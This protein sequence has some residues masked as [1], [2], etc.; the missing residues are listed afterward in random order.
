MK[1]YCGKKKMVWYILVS[2][3]VVLL[4]VLGVQYGKRCELQESIAG[5]VLRFHVLANSDSDIDQTLKLKVRDAVG[6]QMAEM[7]SGA[8]SLEKCEQLVAANI[9]EIER[10]AE[11][12]IAGEGHTYTVD[13]FLQEVSFPVKVYGDYAFPAGEYEALEV[14]IGAG[15]GHNWWCVMYPNMCFSGSVYEVVDE[16]AK[17][18]L[19]EVLSEDEYEAVLSSGDYEVQFKYLTFLNELME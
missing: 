2:V 4:V 5:K 1:E 17:T 7:L 14:V 18:R 3:N 10:T 11:R 19:K 16:E 12:V 8:D 15:E 9:G 6:T 13:A